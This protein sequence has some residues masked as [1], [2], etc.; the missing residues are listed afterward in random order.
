MHFILILAT[1]LVLRSGD[2][3]VL[4]AP[5]TEQNG[6]VFFRSAGALYSVPATEIDAAATKAESEAPAE[7]EGTRHLKVSA[8]ERDRLIRELQL[9]HAGKPAPEQRWQTEPPPEPSPDE[10]ADQK[11]EEWRWRHEARAYEESLRQAKEDVDLL[12]TRVDRL[13]GEIRGLLSLG[14][15][16]ES[17]TYQTTQLARAQ[18]QIPAAQL[19]VERAQRAWDQFREDARRQGILP[20]WLR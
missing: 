8:A 10:L 7:A 2:R 20:G 19:E 16:P 18:E 9:N 17:F 11:G 4:D 14:W 13:R 12:V 15:K 1:T 5:Y 3:I 6:V